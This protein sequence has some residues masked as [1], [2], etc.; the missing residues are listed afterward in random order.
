MWVGHSAYGTSA[1]LSL[2]VFG[3]YTANDFLATPGATDTI[4]TLVPCFAAG[5]RIATGRGDIR[6]EDLRIGDRA[7]CLF[8]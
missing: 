3:D 6:V 1:P 4:V 5:T 2:P 7:R 8:G